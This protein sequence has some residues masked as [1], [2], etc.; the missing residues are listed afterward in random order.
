MH[1]SNSILVLKEILPVF[2]LGMIQASA[3][4]FL[5]DTLQNLLSEEKRG[6]IKLLATSYQGQ[7]RLAKR[8]WAGPSDQAS[9][10]AEVI[11]S[12]QPFES[13]NPFISPHQRCEPM[14]ILDDN[15]LLAQRMHQQTLLLRHAPP[16]ASLPRRLCSTHYQPTPLVRGL[17]R[18]PMRSKRMHSFTAH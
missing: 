5:D 15:Y 17:P 14:A 16:H 9:G 11:L 6:D 13:V 10:G 7:L 8:E 12:V 3:G 2:P 18:L 4:Q 1:V